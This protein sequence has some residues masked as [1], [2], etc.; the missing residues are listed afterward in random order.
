MKFPSVKNL[1]ESV[2]ITVERFPIESIFALAGTV[3]ATIKIELT[4]TSRIQENWSL[5]AILVANLGL[6]L[7]LSATLFTESKGIAGSKKLLIRIVTAIVAGLFIFIINP[8]EHGSDHIRFVLLSL[9]FHLLVAF[10]AFT[11]KGH[12]NGFWQFNKTLFLRFLTSALYGVVLFAGLSAAIGAMNFLF[13]FKFEWDTFSI[14]FAWI[15]GIFSTLF[16][17]AGVPDNFE[18]LETDDS[19]PKGLKFFTQYVLIPL[20]MVYVAILLAYEIKILLQWELPKGLV[21][22]LILGYA[23]FGILSLLLVYPIREREENKWLKTYARYFYFLL[24]PLLGLLF[25]AAGTRIFRYGITEMRYFLI[26]LA[27]WLLFITF[28]FLIA[29][30][31]SIKMIPIS[32]S[33][34]ILLSTYGPQS[35]FTVAMHSQQSVLTGLFKKYEAFD[36]DMLMPVDSNKIKTEDATRAVSTIDYLIYR[37][38]LSS[39]QPFFK[40]DLDKVHDSLAVENTTR[41]IVVNVSDWELRFRQ[42]NWAKKQ[43]G[44]HKFSQYDDYATVDTA[45][46]KLK[47]Y[48]FKIKNSVALDVKGYD[49]IAAENKTYDDTTTY[50]INTNSCRQIVTNYSYSLQIDGQTAYFGVLK[51]LK[52]LVKKNAADKPGTTNDRGQPEYVLPDSALT[53]TKKIK[54]YTVTFKIKQAIFGTDGGEFAIESIDAD[55][56]VKKD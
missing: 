38:G 40:Q 11:N 31:Q 42:V 18:N 7:S 44:L 9:S 49:F 36:K 53:L 6:L 5:R 39:L 24:I 23:V 15:V 1:F 12:I 32:L 26:A 28:Y 34:L 37:H 16:F 17:L 52:D 13:N 55:Y 30:K 27:I 29:K 46:S 3:A 8:G 4:Y 50:T 25:A 35:A 41:N 14:L 54:G 33:L 2:G 48:V 20:A 19:Y 10:A 47:T 45:A 51:H 21:S 56:L 22:N 43:L